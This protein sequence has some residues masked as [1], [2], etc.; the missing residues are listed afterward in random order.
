MT[1]YADAWISKW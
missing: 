1:D